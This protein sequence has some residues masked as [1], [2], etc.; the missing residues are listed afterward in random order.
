MTNKHFSQIAPHT[1]NSSKAAG[2][3]IGSPMAWGS[4]KSK[5]NSI[6]SL[7]SL[8][9]STVIL[10]K[11]DFLNCMTKPLICLLYYVLDAVLFLLIYILIIQGKAYKRELRKI[12][13]KRVYFHCIQSISN[14]N[15]VILL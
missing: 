11:I 9:H 12:K 7:S 2:I 6:H 13:L 5:G 3:I 10:S 1:I 8:N 4:P 15:K 14:L